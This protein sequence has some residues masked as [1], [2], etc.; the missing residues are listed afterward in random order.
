MDTMEEF[1]GNFYSF[2]FTGDLIA[3]DEDEEEIDFATLDRKFK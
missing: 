1:V 3:N 2:N